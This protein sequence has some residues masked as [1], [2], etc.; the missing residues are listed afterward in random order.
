MNRSIR[1]LVFA[2]GGSVSP[3][4]RW[5]VCV[6]DLGTERFED[7]KAIETDTPLILRGPSILEVATHLADLASTAATPSGY[8][9]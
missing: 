4:R 9:G 1:C 6:I 8:G 5:R 7:S 2:T 3:S